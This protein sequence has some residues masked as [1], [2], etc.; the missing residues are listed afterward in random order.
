M[1]LLSGLRY[2]GYGASAVALM[3]SASGAVGRLAFALPAA[4]A[5]AALPMTALIALSLTRGAIGSR[6]APIAQLQALGMLLVSVNLAVQAT[7]GPKSPLFLA[8]DLVAIVIGWRFR[9]LAG[10]VA[11]GLV[12]VCE[13]AALFSIH[14]LAEGAETLG[15]QVAGLFAFT[16]GVGAAMRRSEAEPA[17]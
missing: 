15:V 2:V 12:T 8:Y 5:I 17:A 13:T 9:L 1:P 7:G 10:V 14:G 4:A 16:V 3:L 6:L 11:A